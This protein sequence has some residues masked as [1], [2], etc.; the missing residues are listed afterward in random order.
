MTGSRSS[1]SGVCVSARGGDRPLRCT[2]TLPERYKFAGLPE[3]ATAG[4]CVGRHLEI[5]MCVVAEA[6]WFQ[7]L[8]KAF[9]FPAD[10]AS[11]QTLRQEVHRFLRHHI[12]RIVMSKANIRRPFTVYS[13][14]KVYK[15]R[16]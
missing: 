15:D 12:T 5:G 14:S 16:M 4:K 9:R 6:R 3:V 1:Q 7:S 11:L 13:L 10:P 8:L 2:T